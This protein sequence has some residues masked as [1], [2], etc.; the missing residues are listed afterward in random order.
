MNCFQI[1]FQYLN[2]PVAVKL[3]AA[4]RSHGA[5]PRVSGKG[6]DVSN[7]LETSERSEGWRRT[8]RSSRVKAG[9]L[10]QDMGVF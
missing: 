1:S 7:P 9:C 6:R 4:M 8:G 3:E 10:E 2:L 5:A